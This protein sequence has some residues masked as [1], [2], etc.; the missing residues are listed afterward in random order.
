MAKYLNQNQYI[1]VPTKHFHCIDR[2]RIRFNKF[3]WIRIRIHD[4]KFTKLISTHLLKVKLYFQICTLE[5]S[6]FLGSDYNII[7]YEKNCWLNFS[8][9]LY[10]W[11]W[12]HGPKWMRIQIHIT[13]EMYAVL[14]QRKLRYNV[15]IRKF[16]EKKC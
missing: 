14:P 6:S 8:L 10:L 2:M 11:S 9:H 13:A 3:S 4:N 7:F 12:I 1:H 5:T 15:K 16:R